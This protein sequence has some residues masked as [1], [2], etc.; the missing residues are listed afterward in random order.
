MCRFGDT[1]DKDTKSVIG[2]KIAVQVKDKYYS[3]VT[4]MR[5]TRGKIKRVIKYGK[6]NV[7][8]RIGICDILDKHDISHNVNYSGKTAMFCFLDDATRRMKLWNQRFVNPPLCV[9][10]MELTNNL[11]YGYYGCDAVYIGSY[12]KSIKKVKNL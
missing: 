6:N 2:Y 5:Y 9:L 11:N 7:R 8:E 10:K 4:G 1:I 3:P 12:I